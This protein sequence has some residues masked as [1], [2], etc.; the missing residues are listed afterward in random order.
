MDLST[1]NVLGDT[2]VINFEC[3]TG[4]KDFDSEDLWPHGFPK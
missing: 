3:D 4:T 2:P 1:S